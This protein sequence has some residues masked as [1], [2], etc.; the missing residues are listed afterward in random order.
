LY[1]TGQQESLQS[2]LGHQSGARPFG[3]ALA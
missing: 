2:L 1:I 3:S